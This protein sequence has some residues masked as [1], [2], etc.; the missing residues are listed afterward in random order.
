MFYYK[1]Q[2]GK[3][4]YVDPN[5]C[6]FKKE[7]AYTVYP[8]E[9]SSQIGNPSSWAVKVY[10]ELL[11]EKSKRLDTKSK[12]IDRQYLIFFKGKCVGYLMNLYNKSICYTEQ[13]DLVVV[14]SDFCIGSGGEGAVLSLSADTELPRRDKLVA[15]IY[16]VQPSDQ[17]VQKL[18]LLLRKRRQE[19]LDIKGVFFPE[20][21]IYQGFG[22]KKRCIGYLMKR[23]KGKKLFDTVFQPYEIREN[24]QWTRVDICVFAK[25]LLKRLIALHEAGIL[26]G[27]INPHNILVSYDPRELA[28]IDADSFQIERFPCP[29]H[30][31]GFVPPR[32]LNVTDFSSVM[33]EL[34]DEYYSITVLLFEIFVIG[35]H[36][37]ARCDEGTLED[38]IRDRNFV[39]PIAYGD[40]SLTPKGPW[41]LIWYNLPYAMRKQFYQTF[42]NGKTVS[43]LEWLHIIEDYQSDLEL[44]KLPDVIFP[45]KETNIL[46]HDDCLSGLS[47]RDIEPDEMG[48]TRIENIFNNNTSS[49]DVAF[50]QFGT[51][52]IRCYLFHSK[53]NKRIDKIE[54]RNSDYVGVDGSFRVNEFLGSQASSLLNNWLKRYVWGIKPPIKALYA[55]GGTLLRSVSNREMVIN[56]IEKQIGVHF[57]I[58]SLGMEAQWLI[59]ACHRYYLHLKDKPVMLIK[60]SSL[61]MRIVIKKTNGDIKHYTFDDLGL[62]Q[63]RNKLF[64]T[65]QPRMATSTLLEIHDRSVYDQL[66]TI[67]I[68]VNNDVNVIAVGVLKELMP[69][70][71][72]NGMSFKYLS[73]DDINNEKERLDEP[74]CRNRPFVS[75]LVKDVKVNSYLEDSLNLRLGLPICS[76]IMNRL[77]V[78][79]ISLIDLGLGE[80]VIDHKLNELSFF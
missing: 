5:R 67:G 1:T 57:G 39:F 29:V 15:K 43:P 31:P 53:R 19:N 36:P 60:Q 77:Q 52:S 14:K 23:F 16:H 9:K 46:D 50:I 49:R 8:I 54:S 3:S 55:F 68:E 48:L 78:K 41:Q 70:S 11:T 72:K 10:W 4:I 20:H 42:H 28:I 18:E 45:D 59:E 63:M 37:Y 35:K 66:N 76:F 79:N 61:A 25:T 24:L 34:D 74:L 13:Y 12:G 21:I 58:I 64:S 6:L 2:G 65:A 56:A 7:G 22:E 44:N 73:I 47:M 51:N 26:V 38:H 32:L 62:L 27:D 71:E 40:N 80:C 75:Q 33:R 69:M 30:L 17:Q